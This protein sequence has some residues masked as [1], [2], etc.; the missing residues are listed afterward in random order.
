MIS[1]TS[2][3]SMKT[4]NLKCEKGIINYNEVHDIAMMKKHL[5]N[6]HPIN[7]EHYKVQLNVN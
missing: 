7:L 5:L 3:Q 2:F 1:E 4:W 6:E